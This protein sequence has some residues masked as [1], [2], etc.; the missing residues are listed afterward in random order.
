MMLTDGAESIDLEIEYSTDLFEETRVERMVGHFTTLLEAATA[1]SQERLADLPALTAAERE[2][3][4]EWNRTEVS[5]PGDRCLHQLFEEQV[6]RTPEAV[7]VA[8]EGDLLT[9]RQLNERA[10]Q[11]GR[12]LQKLGVGPDALVAIC[13][14][15]SLEMV[16]G[17]LGILK[18][19]GAYVP[20]DPTYPRERLAYMRRDSGALL[21]LTQERLRSRFETGSVNSR[22]LCV[23]TDRETFSGPLNETPTCAAGPEDLAYVIYTSGS[24]GEPKGVEIRHR[25][26]VNVLC[27]MAKELGFAQKD[28]LLAV[29]TISFDIAGLELFLPLITGGQVEVAPTLELRDGFA[30]RERLERSRAT[31]M[32]ATP[33]T[34]AMLIEAGWTGDRDLR[35]LCGGEAVAPA[36]ANALLTRAEEV[37]NVY[38]P[39]ETTIWSSLERIRTG[40]PITIGRPIAN[41]QFYVVDKQ[42]QPVPIGVPG[43]LLVGGDGLARGYL[44]RP[45]LTAE[46]FIADPFS[47]DPGA[48]LYKTGD[49]VRRLLSGAV[50]F[51]GRLDD[52]VKIRGFRV[53]LGEIEMALAAHPA[54]REAITVA[55]EDVPGEKRLVAYVT[56]KDGESTKDLELRGLLRAKL[57]EHTIPSAFVVLDRFPLTPNGKVDR[58]A[59]PRPD[60][61][62][63]DRAEFAPPETETQ[64]ALAGIWREVLGIERVASHDNFFDLGGHSLMLVRMAQKINSIFGI[65][66]AVVEAFE[67]QTVAR[68]A[69]V[70]DERRSRAQPFV[71]CLRQ[72]QAKTPL[73]LLSTGPY[74]AR[75]AKL[76]GGER[77]VYGIQIPWPAG[78]HQ[79]AKGN[80][81]SSF[82]SVE[83]FASLFVKSLHEHLGTGPCILAGH[84]FAGLLAFEAARQFQT[85]GGRV[86]SVVVI[87]RLARPRSVYRMAVS[88]LRQCWSRMGGDVR[89]LTCEGFAGRI[90]RSAFILRWFLGQQ[91]WQMEKGLGL[92]IGELT[93]TLDSEGVPV[94]AAVLMRFY[95]RLHQ[96]YR[97]ERLD[98]RGIVIR[99]AFIDNYQSV[100]WADEQM[101]WSGLF[102]KGVEAIELTGDHSSIIYD[103]IDSL[104]LASAITEAIATC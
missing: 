74:E 82:P 31:V 49:L 94:S 14:E 29:T 50:E 52:Q 102:S 57:P 46:K 104:A 28:K 3:L 18:A 47:G 81:V 69:K 37:W 33:A 97:P 100:R 36:L 93:P 60:L 56:L 23:D 99:T 45:E 16:V 62:S 7:A 22:I 63:S 86:E 51:L 98:C 27:A 17:L 40:H 42:G 58:K 24:T 10:N 75:M 11:L 71:F 67:N 39:T 2:L 73:Y 88:N 79:I 32:Q 83:Q 80:R 20:L 77:P 41:T 26:L 13:I 84:C 54:I 64:T 8:F 4:V 85:Q 30:L 53:E 72:G 21:L 43:E 76:I 12:H 35:V 55:R 59:L 61:N 101:G 78:W 6:E 48:R 70:I 68:L 87:D 44:R 92:W 91:K 103:K 34:W 89:R 1:N 96:R 65:T 19:G 5:Y 90:N 25:N 15:R 38:G 66:L 9:Y 95:R